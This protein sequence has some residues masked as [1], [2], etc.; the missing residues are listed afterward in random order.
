MTDNS[1]FTVL[2]AQINQRV[3]VL[4][5]ALGTMIQQYNLTECDFRGNLFAD[6]S[7]QI[8]GDN[9]ILNLTRPDVIAEI[10]EKY[11]K[12]DADII[13][14]NTF[15]ATAISQA[16]Y[17]MQTHVREMNLA[18]ARLARKLA[19]CYSTPEKPRFV[20]GSVGPTNKTC[21]M[22]P[23]VNDPAYRSLSFEELVQAYQ[24]QMA[25]LIEG[26]VDALLIETIFD[27]LN[28]KAAIFAAEKTMEMLGKKVPLMLSVTVSDVGGRT[29][30]GQTLDAF[31]ASVAHADIFSVGLNCSFGAEQMKP[32]LR[33]LAAHAP[34]YISVYPNA[35]LPNS[36]GQY[37]ETPSHMASVIKTYLDEQLVN[38]VGG[39]CGTTDQYIAAYQP[40][41]KDAKP[42]IPVSR[43]PYLQ[44]SGLE[45]LE[46]NSTINFVNVGERCNVAGSRKFLRLIKEKN[47]DEALDIA[48]KQVEDGAQV[49]DINMDDGLLDAREEMKHFLNLLASEPEIAR[50][51]VMIDSSKWEVIE[52]GLQCLQGKSVVNSISLKEGEEK[53]IAQA[54]SLR[55]YGA[56]VVVMAFDEQGQADTY[57]RKIDVCERAFRLLTDQVGFPPQDIIF[58]P[59]ILAVATGMPEHDNY[60]LDY[61]KA[62][63][64]IR[65]HLKGV[66]I[67]GGVSNLSF[68]FRGNNYIREAMHAVFLYHAIQAGMDMGIVNPSTSVLYSD[69]PVDELECIEDVVL[70]RRKD[71]ADRLIALAER[72]KQKEEE[73]KNESAAPQQNSSHA[74]SNNLDSWRNASLEERLK[75]ALTKGLDTYLGVDLQEALQKYPKAV[76]I[77]EGPLMD[78]MNYVGE[79]FGSGKMFLPQVVKTARTMKKAVSIL[80]PAIEAEKQAGAKSAGKVLL[81]TVK[82]DVHDIGKNIVSVVMACNGYDI[83]DLGTMVPA[84]EIV[85][86]AIREKVDMIGLSGLITPSLDEMVQV[87]IALEKAGLDIPLLIGGATT[88]QLHTALKIAPVYHAPV[89]HLKDASQ[90]PSV[91]ARLMNPTLKHELEDDLKKEYAQL[92]EKAVDNQASLLSLEEARK[93][94]INLF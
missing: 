79:L 58:D 34:Y 59:N 84:E 23:D 77:I 41:V 7:Q 26:G 68:S 87:A 74:A 12:A 53:F 64:W 63:A 80:Q 32:F 89:V 69:I 27:T 45:L 15:N 62:T 22:S 43:S 94:K 70:N 18:G 40:L 35:G 48:R 21:S 37:D 67:S 13:E 50:V 86:T 93:K 10:H 91:A 78:G 28:A 33:Q 76:A 49:L 30:S 16:D 6:V 47:Y 11:L 54:R 17:G 71:A 3:L 20:A 55:K 65:E 56:A 36:L 39:C 24:E 83:I 72:I 9:D 52:T 60:A 38:I 81:A 73:K 85:K 75:Y 82:G 5:G 92:R 29:L 61:I 44:L 14:T 4:D 42:H 31:L 51:P 66:H 57:Q 2:K 25:A 90:N 88:S 8:K 1:P 19:D 46:V